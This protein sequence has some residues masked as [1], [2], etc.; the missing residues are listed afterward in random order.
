MDVD[1]ASNLAFIQTANYLQPTTLALADA[2][3]GAAKEVKQLRPGST[4]HGT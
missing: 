4:P 2:A 3:A 1:D